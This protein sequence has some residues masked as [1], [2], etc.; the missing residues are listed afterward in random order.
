MGNIHLNTAK[1][2]SRGTD[3]HD[4]NAGCTAEHGAYLGK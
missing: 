3:S 1:K 4:D 2:R